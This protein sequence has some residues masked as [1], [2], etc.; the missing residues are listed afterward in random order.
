MDPTFQIFLF[1]HLVAF[2]V[3][4]ATN[5]AM[6]L[7]G[8]RM[9][10]APPE[11]M[12]AL[13]PIARQLGINGRIAIAVL[14]ISGVAL[15][16]LRYG[17]VEAMNVWFWAKMVLV[18]LVVALMVAGHLLP[19]SWLSPRIFSPIMRLAL[20]GIVLTAVFAFN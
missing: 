11:A 19:R 10:G 14:V 2:G 7:V 6:P 20:L 18:A 12:A 1:I 16:Q 4:V 13:A 8:R 3:A 5:V 15:V 9:A 17:G